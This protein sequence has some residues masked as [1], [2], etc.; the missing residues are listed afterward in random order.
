MRNIRPCEM[1]TCGK[2]FSKKT[3]EYSKNT[4]TK[5]TALSRNLS[6]AKSDYSIPEIHR[7]CQQNV[8]IFWLLTGCIRLNEKI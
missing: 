5:T 7:V 2:L 3:Q 4:Q 8:T 1:S 6:T